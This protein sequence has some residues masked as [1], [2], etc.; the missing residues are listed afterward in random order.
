MKLSELSKNIGIGQPGDEWWV[1]DNTQDGICQKCK[2]HSSPVYRLDD[3]CEL[4]GECVSDC[5]DARIE[6]S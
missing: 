4:T 2:E 1:A 5:C 3:D 6:L